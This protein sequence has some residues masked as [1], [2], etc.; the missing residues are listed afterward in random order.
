MHALRTI[1]LMG[2]FFALGTLL[3]GLS[4]CGESAPTEPT[5]PI[6]VYNPDPKNPN[7]DITLENESANMDKL[8][9]IKKGGP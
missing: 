1:G 4:G 8:K 3:V 2:G 5:K 9:G 6:P 7:K